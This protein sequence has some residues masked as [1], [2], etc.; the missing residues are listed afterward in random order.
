MVNMCTL[1]SRCDT[2][3]RYRIG[4]SVG[5]DTDPADSN[6][7]LKETIPSKVMRLDIGFTNVVDTFLVIVCK[8]YF[9]RSLVFVNFGSH[10]VRLCEQSVSI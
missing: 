5:T 8:L 6:D 9:I 1:L 4:F 10:M 7:Y 3:S 2:A